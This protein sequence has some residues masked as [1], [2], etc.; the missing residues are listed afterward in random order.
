MNNTEYRTHLSKVGCLKE[1]FASPGRCSVCP[2]PDPTRHTSGW[3]CLPPGW[4]AASGRPAAGDKENHLK[5]DMQQKSCFIYPIK[6]I[7]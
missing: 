5:T 2:R 3:T 6:C 1:G 7:L 4:S